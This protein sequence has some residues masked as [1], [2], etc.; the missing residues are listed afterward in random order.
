MTNFDAIGEF[1]PTGDGN[2]VYR[3]MH[4]VVGQV[5]GPVEVLTSD[6]TQLGKIDLG[7][8][9]PAQVIVEG[10]GISRQSGGELYK[11]A[12]LFTDKVGYWFIDGLPEV[13]TEPASTE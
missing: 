3:D 6:G 12:A 11:P 1:A 7:G 5:I 4:D 9:V 10:D 2:R 13:V 8:A